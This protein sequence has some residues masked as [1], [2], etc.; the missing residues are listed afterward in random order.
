M[1]PAYVKNECIL[2]NPARRKILQTVL[3]GRVV[4]IFTKRA[5]VQVRVSEQLLMNWQVPVSHVLLWLGDYTV[6]MFAA[7][8]EL[9]PVDKVII[10]TTGTDVFIVVAIISPLYCSTWATFRFSYK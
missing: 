6:L 1:I 3:H 8:T 9:R 7:S 10:F 4:V 2:L 5:V